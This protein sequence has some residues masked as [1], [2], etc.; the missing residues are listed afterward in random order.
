MATHGEPPTKRVGPYRDGLGKGP[1]NYASLSPLSFLPKAA[2]VHPDRVAIVHGAWRSTWAETYAR[3]RRLASAL[4]QR[5]VGVGDTVAIMAPNVP[6]IYEAHFGVP[7]TGAVLNTLNI[8]LDAEA[9]AFQLTH[10]EASVLITD[11]EFSAVVRRALAMLERRPLVIDIDDPLHDGGTLLGEMDYEAL[12]RQGDPE[13]DWSLPEDEFGPIALNYTSGTTGNP[14]GVVTHHRGAYLNAISQILSWGMPAHSVYLWTLPMFHCNGWCFP[15]AMA[16]NAGTNICQRRVDAKLIFDSIREHGVTH[17]CG[18]P[19]I[20]NMLINA[21][22]ELRAGISHKVSAYIAGAAPPAST[23]EGAERLGFDI[24]HVYGLTETYGPAALCAKQDEWRALPLAER[25][26][27]NARQG[28]A[29]PMQEAMSVRDPATMEPVPP[30]GETVGEIMFRGN[31]TMNGYLKN[32]SATAEAFAGGWLH[33]GDL[34][35]IEP[36]GYVRIKDRS[37]DVIISGGEN[38]SSIEVE[39]VLHRHP[40]VDF[41]AVVAKPDEKWGEVPCAFVE[42]RPHATATAAEIRQFCREQMA[43]YKVPK[44]VVLGP[45]PKSATGKIQKFRLREIAADLVGTS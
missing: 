23:I 32:P 21:P 30:D 5:G 28:V 45:I 26:R 37:K 22:P 9:V 42:L 44:M 40:A 43:G 36:D 35:V 13:F 20:Y 17:M 38:I 8:R 12:L 14:K 18:A 34:A 33:T 1:A 16:A 27:L 41:A 10:G 39:D 24:T 31:I 11:R 3:C 2:A 7:M 19:I 29:S 6:A 25:A 4:A 15:W